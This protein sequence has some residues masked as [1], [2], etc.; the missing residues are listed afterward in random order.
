MVLELEEVVQS[1]MRTLCQRVRDSLDA[2]KPINLHSGFRAI[3]I[4]I[5]TDYAF[6]NC[7]NSLE[8]KNFGAEFSEMVRGTGP[9]FWFFQQFPTVQ[10]VAQG[11]PYWLA[12]I[13]SPSVGAFLDTQ[14]VRA[15]FGRW[16][17]KNLFI[18]RKLFQQRSSRESA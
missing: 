12:E 7:Y 5:I 10:V 9:I 15:A 2:N 6:N 3:S 13:L 16:D 8:K 1:K 17:A 4:D 14:K 11:M 18:L